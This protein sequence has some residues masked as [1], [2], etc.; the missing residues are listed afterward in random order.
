MISIIICTHNRAESLT[1]TLSSLKKV[2]GV[3]S[4]PLELLVVDNNSKDSTKSVV[5]DFIASLCLPCR[6][7][8]ESRPGLSYARNA[9]ISQARGNIIAFTDDDVIVHKDWLSNIAAAFARNSCI[10]IGGRI[11]PVWPGPKPSWF[12]ENGP[13]ATPKAIVAFDLGEKVCVPES[14]PYGANMAFRREAFEKYGMFRV[15]LGR[16]GSAL[17]GGEDIEYFE[18]LRKAGESVLYIPE[19]VVH[20]PVTK[21]RT[22]KSY[23][24]R[25]CFSAARTAVR[26]EGVPKN[27]VYYFGLPR[28]Y[29]RQLC[30]NLAKF[31][32]SPNAA[33][34]FYYKLQLCIVLG[35]IAET[36]RLSSQQ[37]TAPAGRAASPRGSRL[38]AATHNPKD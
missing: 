11:F 4:C 34:R 18:R 10:G 29:F 3:R 30:E 21:E 16:I 6:Y 20:H 14:H 33:R 27:A 28:F 25:W 36:R 8:F 5:E 12:Q 26:F 23:F 13:F 9:G 32:F 19:V 17:L 31:L 15:D 37:L 35:R 24:V 1:G 7:I 22:Q 38:Y 2:T